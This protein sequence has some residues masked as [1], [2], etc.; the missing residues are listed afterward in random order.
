M[1]RRVMAIAVV[2]ACVFLLQS[3]HSNSN[4]QQRRPAPQQKRD[5]PHKAAGDGGFE[6]GTPSDGTD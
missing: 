4:Q 6:P 2:V 1:W 3:C 5:P